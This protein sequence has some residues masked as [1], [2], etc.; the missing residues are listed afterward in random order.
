MYNL[1]D[2]AYILSN[3]IFNNKNR[4]RITEI[5]SR[6]TYPIDFINTLINIRIKKLFHVW[7]D[8]TN[9]N[10]SD[11]QHLLP[12]ILKLPDRLCVDNL[13]SF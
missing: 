7:K 5:L 10:N 2:R 8:T 13:S 3:K 4:Q 11:R 1:V 9:A 6:N 12:T